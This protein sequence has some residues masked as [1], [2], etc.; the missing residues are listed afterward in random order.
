MSRFAESL[1]RLYAKG[2][3]SKAKLQELEKAGKITAD[4][5]AKILGE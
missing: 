3:V 5:L 1:A 2:R 4:E